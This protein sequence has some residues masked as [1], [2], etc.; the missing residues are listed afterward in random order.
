[1]EAELDILDDVGG[2]DI[3]A[4]DVGNDM[5]AM[6]DLADEIENDMNDGDMGGEF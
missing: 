4:D 5:N 2:M 6:D 1:M 3:A